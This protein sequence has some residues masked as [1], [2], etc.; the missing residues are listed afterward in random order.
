MYFINILI[1]TQQVNSD[2]YFYYVAIIKIVNGGASATIRFKLF[3]FV[4]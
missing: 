4:M 1:I 2:L 3:I